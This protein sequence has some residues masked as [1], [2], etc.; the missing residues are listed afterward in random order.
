MKK[1]SLI[2]FSILIVFLGI[3][4]YIT[5]HKEYTV[6][7]ANEDGIDKS[8]YIQPLLGNVKVKGDCDTD[9][10]FTDIETGE[11]L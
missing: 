4:F 6:T 2:I 5:I 1:K 8:E 7:L 9:V 11:K 3:I 10:V